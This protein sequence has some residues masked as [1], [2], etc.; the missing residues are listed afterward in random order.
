MRR[1]TLILLIIC[2][3][4]KVN[5]Q[6]N[7]QL[8]DS[9][10]LKLLIK[11]YNSLIYQTEQLQIKLASY[12]QDTTTT[13]DTLK[14]VAFIETINLANELTNNLKKANKY[15]LTSSKKTNEIISASQVNY[16]LI[17]S[18]QA[19]K[20]LSAYEISE[21]LNYAMRLTKLNKEVGNFKVI[22][23]DTS[24]LFLLSSKVNVS[25]QVFNKD[26]Q[27]ESGW[28][29][30]GTYL[31]LPGEKVDLRRTNSAGGRMRPG[32][33]KLILEKSGKTLIKEHFLDATDDSTW[34][35]DV[36]LNDYNL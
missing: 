6:T 33:I 9:L 10:R 4:A 13:T 19:S 16:Y 21:P 31:Y 35:I 8:D 2:A 25:V 17:F 1:A 26:S 20:E 29:V 32:N 14:K 36:Y 11:K 28:R 7:M 22:V 3:I 27:L 12:V 30:S 24:K 34:K 15:I 23:K 18:E 5:A